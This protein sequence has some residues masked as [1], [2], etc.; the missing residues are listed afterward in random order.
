LNTIGSKHVLQVITLVP[1][2]KSEITLLYQL[3][4]LRFN[5]HSYILTYRFLLVVYN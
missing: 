3:L 2:Y 1:G 5:N 4:K